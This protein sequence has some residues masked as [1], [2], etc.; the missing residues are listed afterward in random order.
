[1]TAAAPMFL[2]SSAEAGR[3][4]RTI[5]DSW[6]RLGVAGHFLARNIDTD[7]EFGFAVDI[8]VPLASVAKVPIALAVLDAISDG[9][10]DPARPVRIDPEAS[11]LGATGVAAFRYPATIALGDLLHQTLAVSDN[12]SCDALLDLLGLDAVADRLRAWDCPG[13]AIRHRLQ[14]LYDCASGAV[15][16]DFRL[17]MELAIRPDGLDGLDGP[18]PIETLNVAHGNVATASALVDLLQRV[19]RDEIAT[20]EATAELRRLM[21]Q[22]VF[23]HRLA[24]DLRADSISVSAKTGTFL[25]LRHEIGVVESDT[26]GRVAIAALTRSDRR[27]WVA[28]DIDLAIGAAAR[29][30]FEL[31]R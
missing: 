12:A 10:L 16:T 8:L 21:G 3:L 2:A 11:S 24:S 30:A 7:E 20:P 1:M 17:A 19:W 4:A 18:H 22:Q 15:G 5:H 28:Q 9:I 23:T 13:I 31:L 14:R 25:N 29:S 27:A 26:G 6:A